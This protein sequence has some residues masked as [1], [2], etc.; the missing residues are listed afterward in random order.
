VGAVM[1]I[2]ASAS[3][4]TAALSA[5]PPRF[6]AGVP[7]GGK[8][9][10]ASCARARPANVRKAMASADANRPHRRRRMRPPA[11]RLI[12]FLIFCPGKT[13]EG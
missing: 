2:G 1:V 6:E 13:E 12:L 4:G 8:G 10:D 7:A 11:I 5:I 3:S 9:G